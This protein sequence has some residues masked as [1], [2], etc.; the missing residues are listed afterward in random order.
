[1]ALESFPGVLVTL[2]VQQEPDIGDDG[3]AVELGQL[4]IDVAHRATSA[5]AAARA[6]R[7]NPRSRATSASSSRS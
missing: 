7:L 5:S 1:M 2:V 4:R 3:R 6:E